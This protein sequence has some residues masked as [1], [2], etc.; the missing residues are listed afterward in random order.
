MARRVEIAKDY[1]MALKRVDYPTAHV[2]V[3]LLDGRVLTRSAGVV[4]GDAANPVP[5][6]EVIAKFLSLASGPLGSGRAREVIEAVNG[7]DGLKDIRD[8]SALL[9]PV[10][11]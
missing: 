9:V 2:R 6:D 8:L 3:E 7:V 5:T 4:R 10:Q 11:A 1:L